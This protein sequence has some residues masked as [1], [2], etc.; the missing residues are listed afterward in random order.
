[1]FL[2]VWLRVIYW[3]YFRSVN[4]LFCLLWIFSLWFSG[5]QESGRIFIIGNIL[6]QNLFGALSLISLSLLCLLGLCI[7]WLRL[8]Q[9]ILFNQFVNWNYETLMCSIWI[10]VI[11]RLWTWIFWLTWLLI[12]AFGLRISSL[13]LFFLS[14]Y[15]NWG[16]DGRLA[17]LLILLDLHIGLCISRLILIALINNFNILLLWIA[18]RYINLLILFLN[19]IICQ[20]PWLLSTILTIP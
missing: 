2:A 6:S 17:Q 3:Y 10:W 19:S 16:L 7:N 9:F 15:L 1:L 13:S 5:A 11:N 18:F 4:R 14:C 20:I 12:G 8:M